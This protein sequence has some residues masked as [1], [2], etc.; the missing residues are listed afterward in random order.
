MIRIKER[1]AAR[2][3]FGMRVYRKGAL[4]ETYEDNNLIVN[5]ARDAMARLVAGAGTGKNITKIR[6]GTGTAPAVPGDA[7]ITRPYTKNVAGFEYPATGQVRINW[8]LEANEDN[9]TAIS[10]FGLLTAD[11]TL[12]ARKARDTPLN[13]DSDIAIE[14][15]WIITF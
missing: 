12:F 7:A 6:L 1:A 15:Q 14:G 9:D 8:T 3:R 13:K 10:E 2:G 5:G 4:V 11:G